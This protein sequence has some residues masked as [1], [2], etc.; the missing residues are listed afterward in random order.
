MPYA[1]FFKSNMK[2]LLLRVPWWAMKTRPNRTA[3][4][5]KF[6]QASNQYPTSS[7]ETGVYQAEDKPQNKGN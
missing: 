4:S 1:P 7:D 5:N 3:G 6:R 2:D